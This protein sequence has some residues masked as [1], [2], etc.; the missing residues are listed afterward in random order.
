[1]ACSLETQI[2]QKN[3]L[4]SPVRITISKFNILMY[5]RNV[6]QK[7]LNPECMIIKGYLGKNN[8]VLG[9]RRDTSDTTL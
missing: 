5:C 9:L 3:E 8:V 7:V 1:M 4:Q 2:S 6:G